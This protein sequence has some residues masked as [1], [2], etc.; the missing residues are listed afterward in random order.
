MVSQLAIR[1]RRSPLST[2]GVDAAGRGPRA[3]D[4]LPD[5]PIRHGGEETTL[6]AL[7]AAAGWH[8]LDCGKTVEQVLPDDRL[9]G[10]ITTHHLNT[11]AQFDDN[12]LSAIALH[13][14]GLTRGD[15]AIYLVRPDGHIGYRAGA[16]D[17]A[18]LDAYLRRWL[19]PTTAR[20][21]DRAT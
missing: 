13:R 15:E 10:V 11:S 6:H 1:Y 7:T 17:S 2:S 4:R 18:G 12:H 16:R 9:A 19:V 20:P 5:A 21:H 8:L 3:G 14:L